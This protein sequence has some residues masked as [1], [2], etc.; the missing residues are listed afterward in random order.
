MKG[1][2][3]ALSW[4]AGGW[5]RERRVW[6]G[7]RGARVTLRDRQV[8]H[9]HLGRCVVRPVGMGPP[10]ERAVRA[11]TSTRLRSHAS[12][13]RWAAPLPI[14]DQPLPF[15]HRARGTEAKP[16]R[17]QTATC[18]CF[19]F[20]SWSL[21][22]TRRLELNHHR[23]PSRTTDIIDDC[24]PREQQHGLIARGPCAFVEA[25]RGRGS[26]SPDLG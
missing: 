13:S 4:L 19:A 8:A 26:L 16:D 12:E 15:R 18:G 23:V 21:V 5:R 25:A 14:P 9:Y 11:G 20:G 3:V 7:S 6:T 1:G 24:Q 10:H 2:V 17:K 22:P